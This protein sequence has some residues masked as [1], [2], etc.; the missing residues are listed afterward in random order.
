MKCISIL[1]TIHRFP[2][3]ICPQATHSDAVADSFIESIGARHVDSEELSIQVVPSPQDIAWS[4]RSDSN[5][6]QPIP[7]TILPW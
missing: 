7:L 3:I 1:L 4:Q 2:S 6:G 5:R